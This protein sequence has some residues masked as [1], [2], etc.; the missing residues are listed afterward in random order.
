MYDIKQFRPTLYLVLAMSLTGF[1]LAVELPGLWLLSLL[2]L[3]VHG[4]LTRTDRFRPLPRLAAN[5]VT[6]AALFYTFQA[7]RTQPTPIITIGQ[8]L[9][10]LQLVKL[11]EVRANRDYA[12]LL[13]LSLLLMVAGA[14]STAGLA[15]GVLFVAYLFVALYC[16]LLFHLKIENDAALLAQLPPGTDPKAAA[17]RAARAHGLRASA[18]T[19]RQDQRFLARSMKKLAGLV[20]VVSL[21]T[22]VFVFLFFPR[23]AGAGMFGG[24]QF[25]AGQA[26]TGFSDDVSFGSITRIQQNTEIV[27]NVKGT[28][29]DGRAFD[30]SR[31]LYLRGKTFDVYNRTLRKWDRTTAGRGRGSGMGWGPEFGHNAQ[32]GVTTD[33]FIEVPA[34]GEAVSLD[35][36]LRPTGTRTLFVPANPIRLTPGRDLGKVRYSRVDHAITTSGEVVSRLEY[37]IDAQ[38]ITPDDD[39][40]ADTARPG[41][42]PVR[43]RVGG[44]PDVRGSGSDPA[45]HIN[46]R[47]AEYARRPEVSGDA[48]DPDLAA[49]RDPAGPVTDLDE[50]IANNVQRHLLTKFQYTL[51]LPGTVTVDSTRDPIEQFL[52]DWKVGHC[53]YFASS[54]TLMCQS[55]GL[56]ARMVTGFKCDEYDRSMGNYFIVR[57]SHAHAWV[58]VRTPNGWR[59]FDPTSGNEAAVPSKR[60]AWQAIKHFFAFLDY[61]WASSV[62]A[63]DAERRDSLVA[64]LDRKLVE[65]VANSGVNPR[66]VSQSISAWWNGIVDSV[67]RWLDGRGGWS[68]ADSVR[69]LVTVGVAIGL[70]LFVRRSVKRLRMRARARRIGLAA[71]PTSEQLRLARQLGFY[72]R[73]MKVLERHKVSRPPHLTPQEFGQSLTFLPN[74]AFTAV[75]TLTGAFYAVRFGEQPLSQDR[76]KELDAE[77][78]KLEPLLASPVTVR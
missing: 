68:T 64:N 54:M 10:F 55:L 4:W 5:G 14:I 17:A 56:Q 66:S 51:D 58:E 75:N 78:D 67:G 42:V 7:I 18:A 72:D 74:E 23:G 47:V 59:R 25:R 8:F 41:S 3:G 30:G 11:F 48:Q 62:I 70:L 60:S 22:A 38:Y 20:A 31:V 63:Y 2:V 40:V 44:D 36:S 46:P 12:Q 26:L 34:G 73:L 50:R 39:L 57:Q 9:V 1:S 28:H 76:Q 77:V 65:S 19:V 71:L 35:V 6:L 52:Y 61:K 69:M 29:A 33:P 13:V 27:A 32:A 16:C 21:I 45:H 49:K 53:E 24:V 43:P 15:F 37:R